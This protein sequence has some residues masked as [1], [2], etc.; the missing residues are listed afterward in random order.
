MPS[1]TGGRRRGG[2]LLRPLLGRGP[3]AFLRLSLAGLALLLLSLYAMLATGGLGDGLSDAIGRLASNDSTTIRL[4]GLRTDL[5]WRTSLDSLVV[6]NRRGLRVEVSGASIRGGVPGFLIAG[7]VGELTVETIEIDL[8]PPRP[9]RE[10]RTVECVLGNIDAAIPVSAGYLGLGYGVIRGEGGVILDSMRIA[11][12]LEREEGVRL[13]ISDVGVRLPGFG[14]VE[15]SG[16]ISLIGGTVLAEGFTAYGP[17]GSV[18]VDGRMDCDGSL[19]AGIS[20][21]AGTG[22]LDLPVELEVSFAGS[23]GGDVG[24]P[25]AELAFDEGSA[26]LMGRQV[27]FEADSVRATTDS[28]TVSDLQ[29]IS[30]DA[31][32]VLDGSFQPRSGSWSGRVDLGLSGADLSSWM[33]ELEVVGLQGALSVGGS[34]VGAEPASVWVSADV[35]AG[36][37]MGY[38]AGSVRMD[39][40]L[41]SGSL[42]L[43]LEADMASASVSIRG[44]AVV[45]SWP[46]PESWSATGSAELSSDRLLS[47]LGPG[48]LPELDGLSLSFD[49]SGTRFGLDGSGSVSVTGL[50]SPGLLLGEAGFRG[51]FG[52]SGLSSPAPDISAEGDIILAGL[53]AGPV[54]ADS[55]SLS[56]TYRLEGGVPGAEAELVV[57]SLR[58]LDRAFRVSAGLSVEEGVAMLEGLRVTAPGDRVYTADATIT[59]PP[60]PTLDLSDIR[61]SH[62]K[63]RV[64]TG[65]SL[66]A[67]LEEG[68]VR[69]D[70]LWLDPPVGL[71]GMS[72]SFDPAGEGAR[73]RMRV[74]D[75]DLSSLGALLDLPSSLAGKG[76]F[77]LVF[78]SSPSGVSGSLEGHVSDPSYG[79]FSM[80]S[81]TVDVSADDSGIRLEG[82]YAWRGGTRSGMQLRVDAPPGGL[83]AGEGEMTLAWVEM[84][85][86]D[87]GDWLFYALPVPIRT[88]GA[89]VSARME[90]DRNGGGEPLFEVQASARIEKLYVTALG[91]E[92]P[93]LNLYLSYPD[94]ARTGY[95]ARLTL[96]AGDGEAGSLSSTWLAMVESIRPLSV[97]DYDISLEMEQMQLALTGLGAVLADGSLASS[98]SGLSERPM[99]RGNIVLTDGVFGMP[100]GG[101]GGGNGGGEAELPFDMAIN[102]S[103]T[104]GLWFRSNFADIELATKLRIITIERQPTVNGYVSAVRGTIS[105]LQREFRITD[106]RVELIQGIPPQ[107]MLD[108]TA[109]TTVR[110]LMDRST[111]DI[112]VRIT[113]DA[114]SPDIDLTGT[115]PAGPLAQED[116]LT[117]LSV[118][119]TYGEMQQLNTAALREQVEGVAQSVVGSLIARNVRAEVGLDTFELTPELFSDT[120][121]LVVNVGKYVLPNLYLSYKGDVFSTSPGTFSAQYLFS[122]DL[123][124]EASTRSTLH[125]DLEPTLELHYTFRY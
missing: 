32:L 68:E 105:M 19:D 115:G 85:A 80:D 54:A 23:V 29:V 118:G 15:G 116:I 111:Y 121:S 82:L 1:R 6:T 28:V 22:F 124:L 51:D 113:G 9:D 21:R 26:E 88:M 102:V 10:E 8:P 114:E 91:L 66:S 45:E 110:S 18:T 125:G 75:V 73:L 79:R 13:E 40:S 94:T 99:V 98:G 55:A 123:F 112:T 89:S 87:L 47:L 35:A 44:D 71:L 103:A 53:E 20:G 42:S 25:V 104:G 61:A 12:A 97:G 86:N 83:L 100:T 36:G 24:G 14:P 92:L 70:T 109:E 93:R 31:S 117:L 74:D 69:L 122:T 90:Y 108:V 37:V 34:G 11:T 46:L 38:G 67:S 39:A 106:G 60:G 120:T 62:S 16:T 3:T 65:G 58:A 5:F 77:R 84:E 95:N 27:S 56:G 30:E 107:L 81:I 76:S 2:L 72:G 63:L 49:A 41:S 4:E 50:S 57:D 17:P 78:S 119:V 52:V 33:P 48:G 7:D 96:G 101:G 64:L 43:D 59:L